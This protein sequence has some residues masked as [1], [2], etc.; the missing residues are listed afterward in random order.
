MTIE[1]KHKFQSAKPDGADGSLIRPSNWNDGH[2]INLAGQRLLGRATAGQGVAQ[3]IALGTGLS[4]NGA[5][6]S[7]G[8]MA[9]RSLT[10]T[11]S[12]PSGGADGDVHFQI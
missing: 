12:V 8:T 10:I 5:T 7:A 11:T 4:W 6:I 1:I 9:G 3:E 2:N